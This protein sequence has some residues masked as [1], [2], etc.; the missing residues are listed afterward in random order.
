MR[1]D[2]FYYSREELKHMEGVTDEEWDKITNIKKM[3]PGAIVTAR[4]DES[5]YKEMSDEK[6]KELLEK[7][8][9]WLNRNPDHAKFEEQFKEFRAALRCYSKRQSETVQAEL[10][11]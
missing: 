5:K 8:E 1:K 6:L 4:L 3:F 7:A 11:G 9:G 2:L 10:F